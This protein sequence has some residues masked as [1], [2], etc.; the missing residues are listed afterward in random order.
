MIPKLEATINALHGGLTQLGIAAGVKNI[1]GWMET[2]E[3]AD[4]TGAKTIHEH[5]GKLK[6]ELQAGTPNGA[7][8]MAS[9]KSLGEE[10]TKVAGQV[11]GEAG[12]KI[13][14]LGEHLTK[15]GK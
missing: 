15:A 10:T 9:L 3:Q 1:D 12:Q 5:L 13:A 2:L 8:I 6:S 11:D 7:A 4:F 14:H